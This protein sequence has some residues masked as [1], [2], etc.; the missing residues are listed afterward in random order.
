MTDRTCSSCGLTVRSG[1]THFCGCIVAASPLASFSV[2]RTVT[3][4][5]A[6][7]VPEIAALVAALREVVKCHGIECIPDTELQ[8]AITTALAGLDHKA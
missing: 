1:D 8:V 5:D 4:A 2:N 3:L 6:L 7:E